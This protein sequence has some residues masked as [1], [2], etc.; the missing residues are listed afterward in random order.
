MS[1]MALDYSLKNKFCQSIEAFFLISNL[2]I[3]FGDRI[4]FAP[5]QKTLN[6]SPLIY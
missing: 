3:A 4:I 1:L 6:I 2:E 5:S